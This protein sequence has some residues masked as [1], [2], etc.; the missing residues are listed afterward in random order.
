MGIFIDSVLKNN[1][2]GE[3]TVSEY[4]NVELN[5]VENFLRCVITRYNHAKYWRYR[6]SVVSG[7]KEPKIAK[8][9]KLLYLKRQDAFNNASMG[10]HLGY[11]AVFAEPP[12]LPHG[13]N[14]IIVS[15]NA[16]IGKNARI[17]HQVTIGEGKGGA[18]VVG[19]NVIIGAGC[20][21]I[22][23]IHIGDNVSI[24]PGCTVMRD[25]PS[26]STVLPGEL[27]IKVK[28]EKV[29]EQQSV[30]NYGDIQ[31]F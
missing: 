27:L 11:G 30:C 16:I 17:F 5:K 2:R 28:R 1:N 19:D 26:N 18:P 13:L 8:M 23:G 12:Q 29:Y 14:G 7:S 10:T 20:K 3:K 31:L 22:G 4:N 21:L 24:A 6:T 15:H 9:W 25:I